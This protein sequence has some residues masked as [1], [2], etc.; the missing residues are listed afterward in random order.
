MK[1][2]AISCLVLVLLLGVDGAGVWAIDVGWMQKGVRVWYFGAV[3]STTAS[4][5]EEAYLLSNV[6]GTDVQVTKHS[7]LNHWGTTNPVDTGT[8]SALGMGPCW[9]HPQRLQTLQSG[10]TWKGQVI[11]TVLRESH[12]YA[13]F[14]AQFSF[15]YLLLPI[16]TLFDLKAQRDVVKIVYYINQYSTGIAYFDADTGLMLLYETSNGLVTVFF[17]LSEINYDFATQLAFAEDNG[18]HTGFKS[19]VLE[20]QMMPWP[21]TRSGYLFFQS[22]VESRYGSTVQMWVSMSYSGN[23]G[24]ALPPYEN[25]CFF[26]SVPILRHIAMSQAAVYPPDQWAPYGQYLW[27]WVPAGALQ[28]TAINV[29]DTTMTRTATSPYTFTATQQP[30]SL[31]FPKLWFDNNGYLT[32]FSAMDSATGLDIDPERS[33]AYYNNSTSVDGVTYY[34]SSMGIATPSVYHLSMTVVSDTPDKGGGSVH[35][36]SGIACAGQG[37]N[38]SGMSGACQADFSSGTTVNLYQTPD[39]DSTWAT[40]TAAGCGTNQSCQVVMS[41][42]RNLT[43]TF[44][45]SPMAK[46]NSSGYRCNSLTEAYASTIPIDTIYGRAVTF[47]EDF[48]LGG[49]KTVTLLGGRDAWYLPLDA[50]TTLQGKL[51]ILSGALVVERLAIK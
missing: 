30:A 20:Q 46:V 24:S 21:D 8:Y 26:G 44:P 1:K 33:A 36:D 31:Y 48:T 9:I 41:G 34:V 19:S 42:D 25:F 4:D 23:K 5:A 7:G 43:V 50:W 37:S 12:T 18:P 49:N 32:Q 35:G 45:Y 3:G 11:A 17:L 6:N 51:S 15:P 14:K 10:D 22:S 16:K 38:P 27:W 29:F 28:A 13:T 40:W 39:S 47:T 2:I